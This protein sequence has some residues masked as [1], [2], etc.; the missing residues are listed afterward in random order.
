MSGN[1]RQPFAFLMLLRKFCPVLL[2]E[3]VKINQFAMKGFAQFGGG[4]NGLIPFIIDQR[5][6]FNAAWP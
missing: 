6:F 1:I 2:R 3:V 4:R 5:C